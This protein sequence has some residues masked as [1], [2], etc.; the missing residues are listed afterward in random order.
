MKLLPEDFFVKIGRDEVV[1]VELKRS[2][3]TR[4]LVW[5]KVDHTD[6]LPLTFF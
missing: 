2:E 5:D 3:T 4:R 6:L 1:I